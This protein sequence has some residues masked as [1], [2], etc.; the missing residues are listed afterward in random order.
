MA[1]T[2]IET[3]SPTTRQNRYNTRSRPHV[4]QVGIAFAN[5]FGIA[6]APMRSRKAVFTP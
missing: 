3:P 2:S 6:V 1:A 5:G 4:L